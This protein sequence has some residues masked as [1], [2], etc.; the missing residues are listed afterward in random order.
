MLESENAVLRR[1]LLEILLARA[2]PMRSHF[3]KENAKG[4]REKFNSIP[5]GTNQ[6]LL[7]RTNKEIPPLSKC[8]SVAIS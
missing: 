1:L 3:L 8:V 7:D 6:T 5:G 2:A 4:S